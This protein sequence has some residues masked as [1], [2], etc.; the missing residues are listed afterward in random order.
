MTDNASIK[1][2]KIYNFSVYF[3]FLATGDAFS[4]LEKR[5][6]LGLP[7]IHGI[8][9]ETCEAIWTVLA[10]SEMPVPTKDDWIQIESDFVHHWKFPNCI[11]GLDGKHV[12]IVALPNSHSLF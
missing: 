5:F 8:I 10:P 4:T 7:T 6:H 1:L 12:V 2:I 11:G 3:S 9:K